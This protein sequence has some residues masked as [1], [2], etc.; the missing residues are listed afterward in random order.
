MARG[1][2]HKLSRTG[3]FLF[4]AAHPEAIRPPQPGVTANRIIHH[5]RAWSGRGWRTKQRK[6]ERTPTLS[7]A[8]TIPSTKGKAPRGV[9]FPI[10]NTPDR[11]YLGEAPARELDRAETPKNPSAP[12]AVT[13]SMN[14]MRRLS[15]DVMRSRARNQIVTIA[16][17]DNQFNPTSPGPWQLINSRNPSRSRRRTHTPGRLFILLSSSKPTEVFHQAQICH[18]FPQDSKIP[19]SCQVTG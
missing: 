5:Q 16:Q 11:Q 13:S 3:C 2:Q 9:S 1:F 15:M 18:S 14:V 12:T 7:L 4:L 19:T 8:L 17:A 10:P 6:P